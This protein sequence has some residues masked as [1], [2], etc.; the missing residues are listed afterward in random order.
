MPMSVFV[1]YHVD[2]DDKA[3]DEYNCFTFQHPSDVR[4]LIWL[5]SLVVVLFRTHGIIF[6]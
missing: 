4:G 5:L 2:G 3:A 6:W 1:L